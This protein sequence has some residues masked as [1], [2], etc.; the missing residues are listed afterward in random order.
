MQTFRGPRAASKVLAE[1]VAH[2]GAGHEQVRQLG[3]AACLK[4]L[5]ECETRIEAAVNGSADWD[6][7]ACAEPL[8]ALRDSLDEHAA[9]VEAASAVVAS[10]RDRKNKEKQRE[11][12]Q[13]RKAIKDQEKSS[14]EALWQK[15]GVPPI[16]LKWLLGNCFSQGA[17][18]A[19]TALAYGIGAAPAAQV[20]QGGVPRWLEDLNYAAIEDSLGTR[21]KAAALK[22]VQ[23]L[24]G[25]PETLHALVRMAPSA[26]ELASVRGILNPAWGEP[27]AELPPAAHWPWALCSRLGTWRVG[28][29]V[30]P[31]QGAPCLLFH[32]P[33]YADAMV[34]AWPVAS[35]PRDARMQNSPGGSAPFVDDEAWLSQHV[36]FGVLSKGK[37]LYLPVGWAYCIFTFPGPAGPEHAAWL[38]M[39]LFVPGLAKT[40]GAECVNA[41]LE[42]ATDDLGT[43]GRTSVIRPA[44]EALC[45]YLRGA[46]APRL[47]AAAAAGP[48]GKVKKDAIK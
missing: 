41:A 36:V 18:A 26:D 43:L 45:T 35:A 44:A 7:D 23:H 10:L 37:C 48:P 20:R 8:K 38:H 9:A 30:L 15:A 40:V 31:L 34:F 25:N 32:V 19:G 16:T 5:Q 14:A 4:T 1:L 33:G 46:A 6:E 11:A 13:K 2:F 29:D 12:A 22:L 39:P 21:S 47:A 42:L 27:D 17:V 24:H 28:V 3:A